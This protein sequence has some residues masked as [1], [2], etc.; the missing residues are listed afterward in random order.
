MIVFL[1]FWQALLLPLAPLPGSTSKWEDFILSLEMIFFG[2]LMNL[3]FSWREFRIGQGAPAQGKGPTDLIDLD[4]SKD[5]G[6]LPSTTATS[7]ERKDGS[8]DVSPSSEPGRTSVVQNAKTAFCPRDIMMDASNN[9]SKR[10]KQHAQ[11]Y[12]LEAPQGVTSTSGIIVDLLDTDPTS[13][14]AS[15]AK[16]LGLPGLR[17][18]AL[19]LGRT[20]RDGEPGEL[21]EASAGR[22]EP[23]PESEGSKGRADEERNSCVSLQKKCPRRLRVDSSVAF[24]FSPRLL[25][26]SDC[27]LQPLMQSNPS[28]GDELYIWLAKADDATQ[29]PTFLY[30][31]LRVEP[32]PAVE[33][34]LPAENL[35]RCQLVEV[36]TMDTNPMVGAF[37]HPFLLPIR[38]GQQGK[39]I[40]AALQDKLRCTAKDLRDHG[41]QH[42]GHL[43]FDWSFV[44]VSFLSC[45]AMSLSDTASESEADISHDSDERLWRRLP[46]KFRADIGSTGGSLPSDE[47]L[48]FLVEDRAELEGLLKPL[49]GREL[50]RACNVFEILAQRAT[51]RLGLSLKRRAL[52][53][54][55]LQ[56]LAVRQKLGQPRVADPGLQDTVSWLRKCS[57]ARRKADLHAPR[58]V[59]RSEQSRPQREAADLERWRG[60]L[61]ELITEARLPLSIQAQ[62][63]RDP[64]KLVAAALG[65][66]R[67]ST[68]KQRIRE[69]R[70]L[71]A[72]CLGVAEVAWPPHLGIVLDYLQERV[73]EPCART[74]PEYVPAALNFMERA[75]GVSVNDRFSGQQVLKKLRETKYYGLGKWS[76]FFMA[77]DWLDAGLR[78]WRD[79]AMSFERDFF[80]PLPRADWEGV[81][82]CMADYGDVVGLSKQL[83]R[84]LRLP[85]HR[86]AKWTQ[87]DAKLIITEEAFHFWT[88]HSE[89]NWL[90]SLLA[91]LGVRQPERNFIGRWSITS[92]ADEYLRTSQQVLIGLQE[93]LVEALRGP[94]KW[95]LREAGLDDLAQHIVN[96]GGSAA[97]AEMQRRL[98]LLDP[99][100]APG[101]G[102][103][104][105][106]WEPVDVLPPA[107]DDEAVDPHQLASPYF[108]TVVGSKRLRRLHRRKG[109]G[110]SAIDVQ[111]SEDVW[112]LKGLIYDLAC[113]HC[114]R[115][116]ENITISEAEE[117]DDS[118]GSC[119]SDTS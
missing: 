40:M 11:D 116:G 111:A 1:T 16:K 27:A 104:P 34:D 88:E 91:V 19:K 62:Q 49:T 96:K 87:L 56:H 75:G 46:R 80:L 22:P 58:K 2:I 110:V 66:M 115:A 55:A 103:Q 82:Q 29:S 118:E 114:W 100:F 50:S 65:G 85:M 86:N 102:V 20:R 14:S 93:Q 26:V 89:R 108:V 36:F 51:R 68:I 67:A 64:Q 109:C 95:G 105:A 84:K 17:P 70:K 94:D 24:K 35:T 15:S 53:D 41:P 90:V 81:A 57:G 78:V 25:A 71:R 63:C 73:A 77:P 31:N 18:P 38:E 13:K 59:H 4:G 39:E 7:P 113:K 69:W 44:V 45:F 9:F 54:P 97:T 43:V 112:T 61:A 92:S 47:I 107:A 83:L 23:R 6:K 98:L 28:R 117:A 37:G 33:S 8:T 3:A 76:A 119:A 32:D 52:V 30:S 106:S 99:A 74:V 48:G 5:R 101:L 60:E 72:F 79:E 10:Y 21:S 42:E 12:E